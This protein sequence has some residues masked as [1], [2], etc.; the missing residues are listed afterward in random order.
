MLPPT[1]SIR[2]LMQVFPDEFH[3]RTLGPFLTATAQLHPRVN[4]KTIVI[5]LLDK[6][7]AYAA[8]EA[9][10]EAAEAS[11][12]PPPTP[13]KADVSTGANGKAASEGPTSPRQDDSEKP[14]TNGQDGGKSTEETSSSPEKE[15]KSETSVTTTTTPAKPKL[16]EVKKYR[17]IP[18]DVKLFEVFWHQVV[19][20]IRARP[21]LTIQDVTALL[22]SLIGLSLS[23]YPERIDYVDQ[24]LTFAKGKVD[25]YH[26]R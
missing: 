14:S 3:L 24:V 4:I 26:N 13:A 2:M 17:G 11:N 16:P 23:C 1:D 8:R 12:V 6:L 15:E 7:A 10:N 22:V 21:D 9:E 19:E 20:L 5:A 25:E 18:E